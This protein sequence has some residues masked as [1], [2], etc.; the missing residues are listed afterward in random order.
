[1][2]GNKGAFLTIRG[3]DLTPK[4]TSYDAVVRFININ[5]HLFEFFIVTIKLSF[6]ASS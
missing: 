5:F 2:M 4:F 1:M 6:S 3:G